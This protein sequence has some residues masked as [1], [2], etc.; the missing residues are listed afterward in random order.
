MTIPVKKSAPILSQ[1][2]CPEAKRLAQMS[3]LLDYRAAIHQ[4]LQVAGIGRSWIEIAGR[5]VLDHVFIAPFLDLRM[6]THKH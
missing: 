1:A 2:Y 6:P 4:P 3:R 5:G